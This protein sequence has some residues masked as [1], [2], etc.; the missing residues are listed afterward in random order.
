MS[1]EASKCRSHAEPV[2]AS[3]D[4]VKRVQG[5]SKLSG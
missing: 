5:G 2:S 4:T 3:P 1:G